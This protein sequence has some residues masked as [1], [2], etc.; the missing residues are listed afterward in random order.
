[1][2]VSISRRLEDFE[3]NK[4]LF[5]LINSKRHYCLDLFYRYFHY[6]CKGYT[7]LP[8]FI[9]IY[10][11]YRHLLLPFC[12]AFILESLLVMFMKKLFK[13]PRPATLLGENRVHLM[14]PLHLNSFPSG[15]SAM[16]FLIATF[17][18]PVVSYPYNFLLLIYAFL[19]AYGRIYSGSHFPLDV[20]VGG[21]IGALCA[22][23]AHSLF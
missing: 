9:L 1:M 12:L 3:I 8:F 22:T 4:K 2:M 20:A 7:V 11:S 16:A 17:F 5:L 18:L 19:V 10:F 23:L 13:A 21:A 14:E 15:D 6:A